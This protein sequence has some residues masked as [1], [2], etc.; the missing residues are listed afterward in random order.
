MKLPRKYRLSSSIDLTLSQ[1]SKT[2][3]VKMCLY[4][5]ALSLRYLFHGKKQSDNYNDET[6][7]LRLENDKIGRGLQKKGQATEASTSVIH[8]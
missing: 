6:D 8:Y 2:I 7:P 4:C 3:N 1:K 5:C